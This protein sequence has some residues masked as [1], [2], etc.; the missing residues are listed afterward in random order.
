MLESVV[1]IVRRRRWIALT[2]FALPFSVAMSVL[3]FL[4]KMYEAT[5]AVVIERQMPETLVKSAV[6][7]EV[8]ARLNLVGRDAMRPERLIGLITRYSLY[9]ELRGR[10]SAEVL[11]DRMRR[12]TK[13][14]SQ[15]VERKGR[16]E[17]ATVAFTVTYRGFDPVTVARV[18]NDLAAAYVDENVKSRENQATMTAGFFKAQL[19]DA[20]QRLA[21]QERRVA[22]FKARHP[23]RLP[24]QLSANLMTLERLRSDLRRNGDEQLRVMERRRA[25]EEIGDSNVAGTAAET[26]AQRVNRL[27]R[28]LAQLRTEF[29]DRYPDIVRTQ[30]QLAEAE[31]QL[32]ENRVTG[33]A[34]ESGDGGRRQRAVGQVDG[35]LQILTAEE[36]R[37]R[38][39]IAT[40]QQ[41]IDEAPRREDEYQQ[42]ARDY[43]ATKEIYR[44]LLNRAE[45]AQIAER[46]EREQQGERFRIVQRALVPNAPSAPDRLRLGL[47][48]GVVCL[49]IATAA[50]VITE[51]VDTS[52][53]SVHEL[54][55]FTRVPVAA[56][57]PIISVGD[58]RRREGVR[59]ALSSAALASAVVL[60]AVGGYVIASGNHR[61]LGLLVGGRS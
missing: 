23:G 39:A 8:E 13:V 58:E 51:Y 1:A 14:E 28:E 52:F 61:L 7:D 4:P 44:S 26:P 38:D 3:W 57:V 54:R 47:M 30:R 59:A 32:A 11:A 10:A 31:S 53:H 33:G 24:E 17:I 22:E 48:F 16:G 35:E 34:G 43:E 9:P 41:R 36:R 15:S 56:V 12:D 21:E 19:N 37:L 18:T 27:K 42:L 25:A 46:V 6:A 40:Y 49:G 60:M 2:A 50:V 45:D 55:T 29:T 5:A 20:R